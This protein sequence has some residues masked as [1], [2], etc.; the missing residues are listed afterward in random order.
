MNKM[1]LWSIRSVVKRSFYL[2]EVYKEVSDREDGK[3]A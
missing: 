3:G 1:S 2:K